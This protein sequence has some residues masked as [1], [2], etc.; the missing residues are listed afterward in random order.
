MNE[1]LS[2]EWV[3]ATE[4][5]DG[6]PERDVP[7]E[8]AYGTGKERRKRH[9]TIMTQ[10]TEDQQRLLSSHVNSTSMGPVVIPPQPPISLPAPEAFRVGRIAA[11]VIDGLGVVS[12]TGEPFLSDLNQDDAA[13]L[14]KAIARHTDLHP[15][16]IADFL[17]DLTEGMDP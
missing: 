1:L 13:R 10:L 12:V 16:A 2:E 4:R 14:I 6:P 5:T 17:D 15:D 9:K 11:I 7:F 3:E 8:G